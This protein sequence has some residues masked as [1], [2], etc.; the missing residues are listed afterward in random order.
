MKN[1]LNE[2]NKSL[3]NIDK[4]ITTFITEK[5]IQD[6]K[7]DAQWTVI[8]EQGNKISII[9]EKVKCHETTLFSTVPTQEGLVFF[10]N[11]QINLITAMLNRL[12]NT[13]HCSDDKQ[14]ERLNKFKEELK[15]D[16]EEIKARNLK[17][18]AIVDFKTELPNKWLIYLQIAALIIPPFIYILTK[19]D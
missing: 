12:E 3:V 8:R 7:R 6:E 15:T 4:T 18:D 5:S 11:K 19:I 14:D 13:I 9:D 1:D 10:V 16:M 2:I 17:K